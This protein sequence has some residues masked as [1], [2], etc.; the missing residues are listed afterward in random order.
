LVGRR[1]TEFPVETMRVSGVQEPSEVGAGPLVNHD[2][3]QPLTE[4]VTS[5]LR[6]DEHVG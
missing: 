1:E 3:D 6:Q 5:V 2:V 4:S